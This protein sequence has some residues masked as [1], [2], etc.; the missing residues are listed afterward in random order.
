MLQL[1][2]QIQAVHDQLREMF[3]WLKLIR[4]LTSAQHAGETGQGP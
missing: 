1:S 2:D 4:V 3:D